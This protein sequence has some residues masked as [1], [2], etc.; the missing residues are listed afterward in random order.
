MISYVY[1]FFFSS[2]LKVN[3]SS[4]MT[5]CQTKPKGTSLITYLAWFQLLFH[6]L[7]LHGHLSLLALWQIGTPPPAWSQMEFSFLLPC[8]PY[9]ISGMD[10]NCII[11]GLALHF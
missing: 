3:I 10:I 1:I 2:Q 6:G 4:H 7:L 9:L 5:Q 8:D 11:N